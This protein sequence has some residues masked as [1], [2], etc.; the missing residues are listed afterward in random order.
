MSAGR[1]VLLVFGIIFLVASVFLLFGGG[2][3]SK[4]T[5]TTTTAST[6]APLPA[7]ATTD[8]RVVAAQ[9]A[10]DDL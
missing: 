4:Q 3:G 10:L 7:L 9:A 5:A 2:G 1:I 6:G 8:P